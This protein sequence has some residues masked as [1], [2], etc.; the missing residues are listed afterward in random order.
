M[1][2]G[3]RHVACRYLLALIWAG[4]KVFTTGSLIEAWTP[5]E[6]IYNLFSDIACGIAYAYLLGA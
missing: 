3:G 5:A 1:A 6:H 2:C 4:G